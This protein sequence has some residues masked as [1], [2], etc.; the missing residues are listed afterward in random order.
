MDKI[1]GLGKAGC[2]IACGFEKYPQYDVYK[3]DHRHN[4]EINCYVYPYYEDPELY[5]AYS[6]DLEYFFKHLSGEALF[7]TCG[8]SKISSASLRVLQQVKIKAEV[9]VLYIK[10]DVSELSG[11]ELLNEN[12]VFNVFQEY[13]RSGVFKSLII[14]ENKTI[15]TILGGLPVFGYYDR[16]N[17]TI[18][19]TIHMLN[20][21]DNTDPVFNTYSDLHDPSRIM[22]IGTVNSKNSEEYTFYNLEEIRE[23]KYY[24]AIPEEHLKSDQNLLKNIREN[25]DQECDTTFGIYSTNYQDNHVYFLSRTTKI[26][27]NI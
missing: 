25:I 3:I 12:A 16:I 27:K 24:F 17:E 4:D 23:K 1:I 19:S 26:Q 21:F 9:N 15:E 8:G 5:D 6:P 7:I 11:A 20:V 22:T 10:P 18:V 13:A 2:N 14:V